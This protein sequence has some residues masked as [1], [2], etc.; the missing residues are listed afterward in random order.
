MADEQQKMEVEETT[1]T[2]ETV[3]Q[4]DGAQEAASQEGEEVAAAEVAAEPVEA[5]DPIENRPLSRI[6]KELLDEEDVKAKVF[7]NVIADKMENQLVFC[8]NDF[9]YQFRCQYRYNHNH[10]SNEVAKQILGKYGVSKEDIDNR[11]IDAFKKAVNRIK[12]WSAS[13]TLERFLPDCPVRV[14]SCDENG[15]YTIGLFHKD[16]QKFTAEGNS[17]AEAKQALALSVFTDRNRFYG[18][19]T[20]WL[21]SNKKF[22]V[23]FER[24]EKK[25]YSDAHFAVINFYKQ[26]HHY[27]GKRS[28]IWKN[29]LLKLEK[30]KEE[31][32]DQF[33]AALFIRH[34][35]QNKQDAAKECIRSIKH[36]ITQKAFNE[37]N[38]HRNGWGNRG[39]YNN[40]GRNQWRNPNQGWGPNN[41]GWGPNQGQMMNPQQYNNF[42]N[43]MGMNTG[44]NFSGGMNFNQGG[45]WS[46]NFSY[47]Q[48][49]W[50]NNFNRGRGGHRRGNKRGGDFNSI[51]NQAKQAKQA[52]TEEAKEEP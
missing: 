48:N 42:Y 41:Q 39:G 25:Q 36:I 11:N 22:P 35:S 24:P 12:N 30:E 31:D 52:K 32:E 19:Y 44:G 1:E 34:L 46:Q 13:A 18:M 15:K 47:S 20:K 33:Q 8:L 14:V 5:V 27:G 28:S 45:N 38:R 43:H 16:E 7:R 17:I 10:A 29:S 23:S 40:R 26:N 6:L 9:S 3:E 21:R 51:M 2:V 37:R 49:N 4:K 50:G